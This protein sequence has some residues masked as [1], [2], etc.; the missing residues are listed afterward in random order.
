MKRIVVYDYEERKE[1]IDEF[2]R[3]NNCGYEVYPDG[4]AVIIVD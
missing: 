1:E 3:K 2:C 4:K